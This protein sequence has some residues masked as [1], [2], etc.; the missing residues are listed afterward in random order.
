[1][2]KHDLVLGE[3]ISVPWK[4]SFN[5]KKTQ[6]PDKKFMRSGRRLFQVRPLDLSASFV[7]MY[8]ARDDECITCLM[9]MQF[10]IDNAISTLEQE[11]PILENC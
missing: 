2:E 1:M 11:R 8:H 4:T 3:R 10:I 9:R 7:K 6:P 5:F